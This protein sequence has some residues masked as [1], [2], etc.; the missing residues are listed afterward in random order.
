LAPSE[1]GYVPHYG[2]GVAQRD[3]S[4]HQGTVWPWLIGAFVEAW[5][6]VR[7]STAE[8]RREARERFLFP[9][10]QHLETAGLGH[11]SEI[12]DAEPPHTPRGCPFQAWSLGELLRLEK[13]VLA[14]NS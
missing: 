1:S 2:G 14:E 12:A 9:F 3:G 5:V 4:Y 8:A 13:V 6:R 11:I 10:H 7:G